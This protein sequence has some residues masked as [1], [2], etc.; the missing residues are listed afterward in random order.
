MGGVF[1]G[2]ISAFKPSND[3]PSDARSN[4]AKSQI[5]EDSRSLRESRHRERRDDKK[6]KAIKSDSSSEY[7]VERTAKSIVSTDKDEM[8]EISQMDLKNENLTVDLGQSHGA[9]KSGG[10]AARS[11]QKKEEE[12]V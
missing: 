2:I 10:L 3:R 7:S 12:V 11:K 6:S 1:G 8:P 4:L 9:T 5:V